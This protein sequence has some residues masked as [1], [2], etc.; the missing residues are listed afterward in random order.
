MSDHP[1][2]PKRRRKNGGEHANPNHVEEPI[3]FDVAHIPQAIAALKHGEHEAVLVDAGLAVPCPGSQMVR[4][5]NAR[6]VSEHRVRV[7]TDWA[8]IRAADFETLPGISGGMWHAYATDAAASSDWPLKDANIE[9]YGPEQSY[10][11]EA[12]DGSYVAVD[13][14]VDEGI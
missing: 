11:L 12:A 4:F 13:W 2:A 9:W 10:C 3:I 6:A 1:P 14:D 7:P 8:D 5:W